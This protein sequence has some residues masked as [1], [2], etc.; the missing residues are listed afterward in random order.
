MFS[1]EAVSRPHTNFDQ[2]FSS[3]VLRRIPS[4]N[5][6]EY[7]QSLLRKKCKSKFLTIKRNFT[8]GRN[9]DYIDYIPRESKRILSKN[10]DPTLD[11]ALNR[12]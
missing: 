10:R 3:Y 12:W 6:R 9:E 5:H 4:L 1:F 11:K 7:F 8:K 2:R